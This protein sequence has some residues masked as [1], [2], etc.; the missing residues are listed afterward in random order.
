MRTILSLSATFALVLACNALDQHLDCSEPICGPDDA[1]ADGSVDGGGD[2]TRNDCGPGDPATSDKCVDNASAV[3]VDS[4]ANDSNPG[5][6]EAPVKTITTALSKLGTK[7]RIYVCEGTYPERVKLNDGVSLSG[8][9]ACTTWERTEGALVRVSPVEAGYALEVNHIASPV[10]VTD[11]DFTAAPGTA[12]APSSIAAWVSDSTSVTLRRCSLT[13]AAGADGKAGPKVDAGI[14]GAA[15][16]TVGADPAG[17]ES[18]CKVCPAGGASK[19]AKGGEAGGDGSTG[20]PE[21]PVSADHSP[22]WDGKGGLGN[23]KCNE[24]G[25]GHNGAEA[26]NAKNAA[27]IATV[28]TLSNTAWLPRAGDNG[29]SGTPGQGGGGGG[30]RTPLDGPGGGGGCGGCG[31][32]GGNGG[33]GGGASIAL[34]SFQSTVSLEASTLTSAKGGAGGAGGAGGGGG[35]GGNGGGAGNS[36]CQGGDGGKG[37]DGG[38][39]GGGAGG[40]S[41]AIFFKGE[42]PGADPQTILKPGTLGIKGAG[43]APTNPGIDGLVGAFVPAP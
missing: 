35:N 17:T 13:A 33:E 2:G 25:I 26:S 37:G 14:T 12:V 29:V 42:K 31:G 5:T 20:G 16:K 34:V 21:L 38:A 43:G 3:F 18:A 32:W 23:K 6:R 39:G 8:G 1:G 19:G 7:R 27:T 30:G 15:G 24:G 10:L 36:G 28:G 4:T 40:V 9:F 41:A 22:P 11:I